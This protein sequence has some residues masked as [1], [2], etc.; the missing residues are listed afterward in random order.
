[1]SVLTPS[2]RFRSGLLFAVA[3][4]FAFGC[5]GPFGKAL[6]TAGWSPPASRAVR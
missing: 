4:A 3:S 5:S 1:M 2:S 6:M